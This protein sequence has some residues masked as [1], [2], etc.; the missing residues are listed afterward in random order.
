MGA[1]A[2]G[3]RKGTEVVGSCGQAGRCGS[4]WLECSPDVPGTVVFVLL[5]LSLGLN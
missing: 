2:W 5:I 1:E 4:E 3:G